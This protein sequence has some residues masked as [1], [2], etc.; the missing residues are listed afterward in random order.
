MT[1]ELEMF[2]LCSYLDRHDDFVAV[3]Q[4][5]RSR[6]TLFPALALPMDFADDRQTPD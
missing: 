2:L 5:H 4:D 6:V 1:A 3:D